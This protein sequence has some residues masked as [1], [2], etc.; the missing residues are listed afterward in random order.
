MNSPRKGFRSLSARLFCYFAVFA[1]LIFCASILG[2]SYFELYP[3][4]T[5]VL[6]IV[7]ALVMLSTILFFARRLG[8]DF[9]SLEVA[10]L[11]I[12]DANFSVSMPEPV[13][14]EMQNITRQ[15]NKSFDELR[16]QRQSVYQ[17]ELLLDTVIEASPIAM[18]LCNAKQQ[19]IF[20][21]AAARKLLFNGRKQNGANIVE[22]LKRTE[23]QQERGLADGTL[24]IFADVIQRGRETLFSV[25]GVL[26]PESRSSFHYS[27]SEFS[28]DRISHRLHLFKD[29][30][31]EIN[32]QEANSW[33][34]TIKII[35]HEL[36]NSLAPISSMAHSGQL[37]LQRGE[38]ER[39]GQVLGRI[40]SGV[41]SLHEF[42][43]RYASFARLPLPNFLAINWPQFLQQLGDHY[44]FKLCGDIPDWTLS[45]DAG[46]LQQALIN[47][48]KNAHE[49]GSDP[50]NILLAFSHLESNT[51]I[52]VRDGGGGMDAEV[53]EKALLPFYSTKPL[54]SGIGLALCREIVEAHHGRLSLDNCTLGAEGIK[55]NPVSAEHK[56]QLGLR[57]SL[58][59]PNSP[60]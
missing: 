8:R 35:S 43:Q 25:A 53:M 57:V 50:E 15:M 49:S 24:D 47:A 42:I 29:I 16:A 11:N 44:A 32:R 7:C 55:N 46:Q 59:L 9:N 52:Q 4:A 48:L 31:R 45:A 13:L 38:L 17:R 21:N 3:V 22:L 28:I 1:A 58:L 36:N 40:E 2:I 37:L 5:V 18:L 30:T 26:E 56:E 20:A 34:Q 12:S 60:V 19:L 54:G 6:G 27:C 39:L 33:K 41:M 51:L 10:L 14:P 23:G